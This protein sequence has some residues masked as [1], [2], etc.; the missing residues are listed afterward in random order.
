MLFCFGHLR[1]IEKR[2]EDI[3]YK[4]KR[5]EDTM[6]QNL[7]D[8]LDAVTAVDTKVDGIATQLVDL[9]S[10]FDAAIEK[11]QADIAAGADT[12]PAVAALAT[13]GTKLTSVSDALSA[14]DVKAETISGTPTP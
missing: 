4:I 3:T 13:L 11:L 14:I 8:V 7:Q 9:S 1:K 5:L 2:L 6:A 10:D 12:A